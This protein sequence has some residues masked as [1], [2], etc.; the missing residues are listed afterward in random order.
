M[1][2]GVG[3]DGDQYHTVNLIEDSGEHTSVDETTSMLIFVAPCICEIIDIGLAVTTA[4][5]AHSTNHW[6]INMTNQ[7]GDAEILSDNFD[8]DSDNSGNGGR[9]LTADTLNSICDNG[10]GTNYLQNAV[11]AKG[12][13]I[14]FTATLAASGTSLAYPVIVVHFRC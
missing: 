4:V 14:K 8:T 5:T 10:S 11:L 3:N 6:T 1:V 7:T 13:M 12:D 2:G 9:S